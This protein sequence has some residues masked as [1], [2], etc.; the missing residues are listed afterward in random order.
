[1]EWSLGSWRFS[2]VFLRVFFIFSF[3]LRLSVS[4]LFF[5]LRFFCFS[6]PFSLFFSVCSV[7]SSLFFMSFLHFFPLFFPFS[8]VPI[9]PSSTFLPSSFFPLFLPL[10]SFLHFFFAASHLIPPPYFHLFFFLFLPQFARLQIF[11]VRRPLQHV[12]AGTHYETRHAL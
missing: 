4:F 6:S 7:S 1:M 8:F 3:D 10:S 11:H 12:L 2:L 5:L 9:S